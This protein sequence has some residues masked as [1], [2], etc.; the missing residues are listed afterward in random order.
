MNREKLDRAIA[1]LD[2]AS[3][4]GSLGAAVLHVKRGPVEVSC[5]F[6]KAK[7]PDAVFL[8]ASL[9]KP[10]TTTGVMVLCDRKALSL[11][12]P[13]RKFI[14]EFRHPVTVR[15]LLTHTSGLPDM[16][17]D[18]MELRRRSA[19]LADFVASTCKVP[20]AFAPGSKVSYQSMGILLAAEIV[21]RVTK[22]PFRDFLKKELF[23]PLGMVGTSLGLGGRSLDE[24]MAS[25][26]SSEPW[27]WNSRYWRDLGAPW[28]GGLG[29]AGDLTR[30]LRTFGRVLRPETAREMIKDHTAALGAHW[31]LGWRLDVQ[32]RAFGHWGSTGTLCWFDPVDDRSFVLLTTKPEAESRDSILRPVSELC[33]A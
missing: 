31:G 1:L 11:A 25:Q 6:G 17:P 16:V 5:S 32:G 24:T 10:M 14:P 30:F 21:E 23:T 4:D 13:V 8:L 29:T 12:D 26:V 7:T 27:G 19:P 9:T 22:M 15:H 33:A 3:A 18:N 20:L 28:G 2:R